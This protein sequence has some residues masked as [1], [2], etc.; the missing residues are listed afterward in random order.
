MPS[1]G[2]GLNRMVLVH[3]FAVEAGE[4]KEG[5]DRF[6]AENPKE[7]S[8]TY[9]EI[10][11]QCSTEQGCIGE[12]VDNLFPFLWKITFDCFFFQ[13]CFFDHDRG[14]KKGPTALTFH[15][16]FFSFISRSELSANAMFVA[17]GPLP[18]G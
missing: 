9:K 4:V 2:D 5:A 1:I 15:V 16:R 11:E 10:V 12:K 6:I 18:P 13:V 7:M 3:A 17:A 14:S 8:R